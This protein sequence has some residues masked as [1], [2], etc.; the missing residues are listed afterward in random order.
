MAPQVGF[1]GEAFAAQQAGEG[2]LFSV[3]SLVTEE[4]GGHAER[5]STCQALVAFGL[6]VN[7]SVVF[8]SHQVGELLMAH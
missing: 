5:L 3:Y 7:T 2:L 1:A 4:L 8:Q 6:C